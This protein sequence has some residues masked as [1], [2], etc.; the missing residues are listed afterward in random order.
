MTRSWRIFGPMAPAPSTTLLTVLPT[1]TS[2]ISDPWPI[3]Q[4]VADGNVKSEV[5]TIDRQHALAPAASV[6]AHNLLPLQLENWQTREMWPNPKGTWCSAKC[7]MELSLAHATHMYQF[8]RKLAPI[9]CQIVQWFRGPT[10]LDIRQ[11][12][13]VMWRMNIMNPTWC[14]QS[15]WLPC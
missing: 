8:D 10:L 6:G 1:K 12:T 4:N 9:L 2:Q 3:W 13:C 7:S 15:W 14:A 5:R 11:I